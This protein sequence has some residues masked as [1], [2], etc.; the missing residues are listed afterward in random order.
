MLR[1]P[2]LEKL[3][4]L[5]PKN[6]YEIGIRTIA[7][8]NDDFVNVQIQLNGYTDETKVY[9]TADKPNIF[10]LKDLVNAPSTLTPELYQEELL[11]QYADSVV[12]G[13][14]LKDFEV[15]I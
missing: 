11:E 1:N 3:G 2:N 12:D 14:A 7:P 15:L 8:L 4:I 9:L 10:I 5:F 13:V 6:I